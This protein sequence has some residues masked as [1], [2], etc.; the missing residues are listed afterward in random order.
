MYFEKK[1]R[2]TYFYALDFLRFFA[3]KMWN[4]EHRNFSFGSSKNKLSVVG[5]YTQMVWAGSHKVGCGYSQCKTPRGK[6]FYNYICNYCP[7]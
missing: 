1:Y 7:M 4:L 3:L 6:T 5:H 2:K